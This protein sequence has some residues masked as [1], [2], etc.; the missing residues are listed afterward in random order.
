MLLLLFSRYLKLNELFKHSYHYRAS[1]S[2]MQCSDRFPTLSSVIY[3]EVSGVKVNGT[4]IIL[5]VVTR[6]V[7]L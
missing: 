1:D 3:V 4:V 5:H 6:K 7:M 2:E